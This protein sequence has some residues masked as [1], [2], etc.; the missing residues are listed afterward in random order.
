M[1][2]PSNECPGYDTKQPEGE[3]PVML[4]LLGMWCTHSLQ[5]LQGPLGPA[6]V[7]PDKAQLMGQIKLDCVLM[8]N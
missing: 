6:A 7:A 3:V 4:E 5:L 1:V 2:R 8:L